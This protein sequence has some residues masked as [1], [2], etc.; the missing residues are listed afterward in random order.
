MSPRE[1]YN[2]IELVKIGCVGTDYTPSH[3]MSYLSNGIDC[4]HSETIYNQIDYILTIV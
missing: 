2:V 4:L 3:K 1:L